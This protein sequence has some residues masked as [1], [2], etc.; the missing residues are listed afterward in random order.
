MVELESSWLISDREQSLIASILNRLCDF[1]GF[2]ELEKENYI[3]LLETR[4][5]DTRK[6]LEHKICCIEKQVE[7]LC[8]FLNLT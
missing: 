3:A 7:H 8:L 1:K 6:Q 4:K 5:D 2:L